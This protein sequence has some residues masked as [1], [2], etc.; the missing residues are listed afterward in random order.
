MIR[1]YKKIIAVAVLL[2]FSMYSWS[3][4]PEEERLRQK[5]K[6]PEELADILDRAYEENS[7]F[8]SCL[9]GNQVCKCPNGLHCYVKKGTAGMLK[10]RLK[11]LESAHR[12]IKQNKLDIMLPHKYLWKNYLVAEALEP[13]RN[14]DGECNLDGITKE[15]F[16]QLITFSKKGWFS[17]FLGSNFPNT[18]VFFSKDRPNREFWKTNS[19]YQKDDRERRIALIDTKEFD[20]EERCVCDLLAMVMNAPLSN[21]YERAVLSLLQKDINSSC[22]PHDEDEF[23]RKHSNKFKKYKKK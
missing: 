13:E 2:L 22:Y 7:E 18:N 5:Y 8:R 12:V 11:N 23:W 17:H 1:F 3:A 19:N 21:P 9:K 16:K 6:A 14:E 4:D 10:G 15:Q 20:E